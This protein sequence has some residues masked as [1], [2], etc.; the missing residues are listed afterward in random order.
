MIVTEMRPSSRSSGI[1]Q[2]LLLIC[3]DCLELDRE[4]LLVSK[5]SLCIFLENHGQVCLS[6]LVLLYNLSI[7]SDKELY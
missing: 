6:F 5:D 7:E 4:D 2:Y 3:F 1:H